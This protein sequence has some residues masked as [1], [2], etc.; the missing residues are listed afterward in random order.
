MTKHSSQSFIATQ[1]QAVRAFVKGAWVEQTVT[2]RVVS[3]MGTKAEIEA[4]V[5]NIHRGL[6]RSDRAAWAHAKK[7]GV[8]IH[9]A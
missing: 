1:T 3:K 8:V 5:I 4:K 2:T 6:N 9:A 7:C